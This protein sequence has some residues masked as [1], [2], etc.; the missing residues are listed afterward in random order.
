M[1]GPVFST[2]PSYSFDNDG[3]LKTRSSFLYLM[4]EITEEFLMNYPFSGV[5]SN[6]SRC[7]LF[8]V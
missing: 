8:V 3:Y 5:A 6:S 4:G 7:A 2:T 1:T